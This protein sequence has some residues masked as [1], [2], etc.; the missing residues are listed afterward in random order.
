MIEQGNKERVLAFVWNSPGNQHTAVVAEKG[1]AVA[2]WLEGAEPGK[3]FII[4]K[5]HGGPNEL[6]ANERFS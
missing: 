2:M 3:K 5:H 4:L 1:R 6:Y